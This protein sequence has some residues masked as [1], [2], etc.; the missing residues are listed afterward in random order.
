M[1]HITQLATVTVPVTDQDV[2]LAFYTSK[3]GLEVRQDF[4]Y[5]TGERWLEVVPPGAP[6]ALTL[7]RSDSAGVETGVILASTDIESDRAELAG[8]LLT[9]GEVVYWAGAPLAGNPAMFFVTDPDGNTLLIV[10]AP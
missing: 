6:T 2:A 8:D 4:T 1:P 10:Q 7:A 3:L 5:E 9:P